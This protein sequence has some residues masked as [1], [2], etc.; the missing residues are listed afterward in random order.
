LPLVSCFWCERLHPGE[1]PLSVCS[2]CA[3]IFS[4][5]RSLPICASHPLG[6]E[7]DTEAH[8]EPTPAS[9]GQRLAH[10]SRI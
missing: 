1:H 6:A 7:P 3:A 5:P 9:S 4:P 2:A 10:R 8:P